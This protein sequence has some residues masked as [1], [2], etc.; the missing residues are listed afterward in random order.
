MVYTAN[1]KP[2]YIPPSARKHG[3]S[4]GNGM[5]SLLSAIELEMAHGRNPQSQVDPSLT[6][7]FDPHGSSH[8]ELMDLIHTN[9]TNEEPAVSH[10][11]A[12]NDAA[13]ETVA[14]DA[15]DVETAGDSP[16]VVNQFETGAY[17]QAPSRKRKWPGLDERWADKAI[18]TE[19][20]RSVIN[21]HLPALTLQLDPQ[22]SG[23][24]TRITR[25]SCAFA[26]VGQ[27]SYGTEKRFLTPAPICTISGNYSS[28][29]GE[30]PVAHMSIHAEE[31]AAES[32]LQSA[33]F[34][35]DMQTTF[36]ALHINNGTVG[37]SKAFNLKLQI[38]E[39]NN[40]NPMDLPF[41]EFDT[42]DIS[43]ISKASKKASR[44][45]IQSAFVHSGST[46][47]L[48]NRINSQ[49]VR[50]KFLTIE[51]GRLSVRSEQWTPF[52]IEIC[53][54]TEQDLSGPSKT[55]QYGHTVTLTDMR[56]GF[57]TDPLVVRRL[58]KDTV[59]EQ[60]KGNVSQMQKVVLERCTPGNNGAQDPT[61]ES[62]LLAAALQ[63]RTF[64][65][66]QSAQKLQKDGDGPSDFFADYLPYDVLPD[67]GGIKMDDSGLWT[68]VGISSFE[69]TFLDTLTDA[70][71]SQA[72]VDV[73]RKKRSKFSMAHVGALAA[74]TGDSPTS[75]V[76]R[77]QTPITPFPTLMAQPVYLEQSSRLHLQ[78]R[79]F[80]HMNSELPTPEIWL[81]SCG[82]LSIIALQQS[83]VF[84]TDAALEVALPTSRQMQGAESAPLLFVRQDGL[85]F[86]GGCDVVIQK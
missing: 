85:V 22:L 19:Q 5:Q 68:L 13:L 1:G 17:V 76:V 67:T 28:I 64:L 60:A 51:A 56:T 23:E 65:S 18:R 37:K 26:S 47:S 4:D 59:D 20:I 34:G 69:F 66:A 54:D 62:P 74:L 78:I 7:Q 58:E 9:F 70:P 71:S 3:S 36:K 12:K 24:F 48:Y 40:T 14:V 42:P 38:A 52:R 73:S 49:T 8:Q 50:T 41:A 11:A 55:V 10:T 81:G 25:I 30:S 29:L 15:G 72:D 57:K 43:I 82:P 63:E 83:E 79:D 46:I 2:L 35:P 61:S 53:D 45:R 77:I 31:S 6:N 33:V 32:L 86:L 44:Q 75:E 84:A 16:T 80:W 21:E 27:K 39:K